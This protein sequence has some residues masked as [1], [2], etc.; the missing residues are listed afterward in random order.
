MVLTAVATCSTDADAVIGV[1]SVKKSAVSL[2]QEF[3]NAQVGPGHPFLLP[4]MR[5]NYGRMEKIMTE[6]LIRF[7][8][9]YDRSKGIKR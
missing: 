7:I 8:A 9:S 4:A 3:G 2:S 6:Q 5:K 1:V